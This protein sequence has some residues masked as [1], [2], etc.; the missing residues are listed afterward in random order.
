MI[1]TEVARE[2]SDYNTEAFFHAFLTWFINY[3][4]FRLFQGSNN[5]KIVQMGK[6][7]FDRFG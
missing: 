4:Q 7:S 6:E 2:I 1:F 5:N 3:N